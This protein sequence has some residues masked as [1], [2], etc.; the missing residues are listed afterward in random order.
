MFED[1]L[2]PTYK[3]TIISW[4]KEDI[5][6]FDYGGF[7]VGGISF[8]FCLIFLCLSFCFIDEL[9]EAT[10]FAKSPGIVSGIPFF[11]SISLLQHAIEISACS[12]FWVLELQGWVVHQGGSWDHPEDKDCHRYR[13][14]SQHLDGR[15]NRIEHHHSLFRHFH[16]GILSLRFTDLLVPQG[17]PTRPFQGLERYRLCYSQDHSWYLS[18]SSSR[19]SQASV[20]SKNT[21]SWLEVRPPTEWTSPAWACWRVQLLSVSFTPLDNHVWATGSITDSVHKARDACGFSSKIEVEART[22]EEAIE[23]VFVP[24]L[25]HS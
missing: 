9:H 17:G 14:H 23:A 10:L 1:L 18:F 15:K 7:V 11:T 3:E 19:L 22:Y 6:S 5:P 20:L 16:W 12:C 2:P 21:P 13:T 4:I 25:F 8:S 24:L